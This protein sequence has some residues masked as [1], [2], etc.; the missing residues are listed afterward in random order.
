MTKLM[1][2]VL[3][4]TLF[5][6]S[7]AAQ[8]NNCA[9]HAVVVERLA[10]GY[11]ETRQ[12]IGMGADNSVVEVFASLETGTWTITITRAGGPTCLVASGQAFQVLAE[13][14]PNTDSGA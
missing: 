3:S 11:G 10:A 6:G 14:L 4:A 8:T 5:A 2:L 13:A 12:S 7:A 9:A 1:T